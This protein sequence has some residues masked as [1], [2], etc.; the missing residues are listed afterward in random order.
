M[1]SL[2]RDAEAAL[3]VISAAGA[4]VPRLRL[5]LGQRG[6]RAANDPPLQALDVF[7]ELLL[8]A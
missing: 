7:L 5:L 4:D 6:R 2:A 3:P 1:Y 8:A